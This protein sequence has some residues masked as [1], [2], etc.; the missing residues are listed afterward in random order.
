MRSL[1]NGLNIR[2]ACIEALDTRF[3]SHFDFR[4]EIW[5]E[6]NLFLNGE[7]FKL[8][9]LNDDARLTVK[10][11]WSITYSKSLINWA[12]CP[13]C[14]SNKNKNSWHSF[15]FPNLVGEGNELWFLLKQE[16]SNFLLWR[17][18]NEFKFCNYWIWRTVDWCEE[19][20]CLNNSAVLSNI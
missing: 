9:K 7:W 2:L 19:W 4:T 13:R 16:S 15:D 3:V 14:L 6:Q 10:C 20:Y 5:L 17:D 18:M 12:F 1:K 8:Y 11:H